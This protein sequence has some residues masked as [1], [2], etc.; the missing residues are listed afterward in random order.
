MIAYSLGLSLAPTL[1]GYFL[2]LGL[3]RYD[4]KI[5]L[6]R[7]LKIISYVLALI[8]ST[9]IHIEFFPLTSSANVVVSTLLGF[10]MPIFLTMLM[11]RNQNAKQA[12]E[13]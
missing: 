3:I 10:I 7:Q 8:S 1:V 11:K 13:I 4:F 6:I 12:D 5:K 9:V 2:A